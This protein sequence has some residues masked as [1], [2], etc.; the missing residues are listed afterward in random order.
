M[1]DSRA[2]EA[3]L[4]RLRTG[5]LG[6]DDGEVREILEELRSHILEKAADGDVGAVLAAMGSPEELAG[7]YPSRTACWRE[8]RGSRSPLRLLRSLF[9][10]ASLSLAGFFVLLGSVLGYFTG[11]VCIL[12]ALCKPFHSNNAGLWTYRDAAG[13]LGISVRLGYGNAPGVGQ[14]LLGWWIV[15]V[16]LVVGCG[17]VM[18]TTHCALWCVSRYRKSRAFREVERRANERTYFLRMRCRHWT[19]TLFMPSGSEL[20]R[21]QRWISLAEFVM[22]GAIV[23]GLQRFHV[24]PNEV[25]ILFILGPD[26]ALRVRDGGWGAMGLRWPVS[27]RQTVLIG[28]GGGGDEN[29]AGGGGG[30]S[31]DGAILA[32][33]RGADRV[34]GDHGEYVGGAAMAQAL[35]GRSL[36]SARRSVTG[37]T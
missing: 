35:S 17:L 2:T 14:D 13:D 32:A 10:W 18:L 21:S 8:R 19:L 5:L 9:R 16:G 20:T 7:R 1:T 37:D 3:Y 27:W 23:V 4:K 33:R 12:V 34:R 15:P 22:G 26:F 30:G 28:P 31:P 24:I 6:V 11:G 25:P 36:P 29:L